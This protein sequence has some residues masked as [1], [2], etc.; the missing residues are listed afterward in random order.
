MA[1]R[2]G[3][4]LAA[5]IGQLVDLLAEF[6]AVGVGGDQLV[7]ELVDDRLQL[8]L[9]AFLDR[10]QPGRLGRLDRLQRLGRLELQLGLGLGGHVRRSVCFAAK[11]GR[12]AAE[13]KGES[14]LS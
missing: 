8:R 12:G 14:V 3:D 4:L 6:G 11:W 2:L 1:R 13:R 5:H 10:H 9:H 7:D